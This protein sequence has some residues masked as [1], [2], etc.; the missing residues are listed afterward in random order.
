MRG[1]GYDRPTA[2][3]HPSRRDNCF[4]IGKHS[5]IYDQVVIRFVG[6]GGDIIMGKFCYLNS[7]CVLCSGNGIL[8]APGV[9]VVPTIHAFASREIPRSAIRDSCHLRAGSWLKTMCRSDAVLLYGPHLEQGAIVAAGGVVS[10][11]VPA[12]EVWGDVPAR[13]IRA[14]SGLDREFLLLCL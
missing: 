2:V 7:G 8:L 9:K 14:R 6:G 11:R 5:E 3:I 12:F 13:K 1:E 10:G 4:I